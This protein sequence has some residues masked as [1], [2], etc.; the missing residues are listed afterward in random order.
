MSEET[1][2]QVTCAVS[3]CG[4]LF[5]WALRTESAE[6]QSEVFFCESCRTKSTPNPEAVRFLRSVVLFASAKIVPSGEAATKCARLSLT[7]SL[8]HRRGFRATLPS[9]QFGVCGI[10]SIVLPLILPLILS[11][12]L[13]QD[14]SYS[15]RRFGF[16]SPLT[17]PSLAA[18]RL[19]TQW[20]ASL[21]IRSSSP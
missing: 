5:S 10:I 14:R 11:L 17:S 6:G 2:N 20:R 12:S 15:K 4:H 18:R 8:I 7:P 9:L 19:V 21:R 16:F 1:I 3:C 13:F